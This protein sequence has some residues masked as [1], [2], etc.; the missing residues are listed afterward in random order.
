MTQCFGMISNIP[1]I[2]IGGKVTVKLS[3]MMTKKLN[4]AIQNA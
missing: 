1:Y 4:A 3:K 2:K